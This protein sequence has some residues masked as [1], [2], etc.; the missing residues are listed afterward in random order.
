MFEI[1]KFYFNCIAKIIND[2]WGSF[3]I[4]EGVS[5]GYWIMGIIL[6]LLILKVITFG[7]GTNGIQNIKTYESNRNKQEKKESRSM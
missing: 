6:F 7:Y 3:E 2:I 5:Y 4:F 1:V